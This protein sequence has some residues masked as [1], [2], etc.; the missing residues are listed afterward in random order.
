MAFSFSGG[1]FGTL[2]PSLFALLYDYLKRIQDLG[3][4]IQVNVYDLSLNHNRKARET[5]QWLA[6]E[7]MISFIGSD[8][9]GFPPKRPPKVREGVDWLYAHTDQEYADCVV[10]KNAEKMLGI[11]KYAPCDRGD[12]FIQTE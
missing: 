5:A 12:C 8:M 6:Q 7:R 1:H 11:E 10:R 9:H 2:L 3:V 4:L